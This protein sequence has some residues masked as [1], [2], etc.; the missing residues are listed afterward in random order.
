MKILTRGH[1]VR[2]LREALSRRR[3]VKLA[4][5]IGSIAERGLSYHD[6]DVAVLLDCN[7][8][9]KLR[10]LGEVHGDICKALSIGDDRLDLIP[11]DEVGW[12]LKYR[13]AKGIKLVD[14]DG[15]GV[16]L[17]EELNAV[18]PEL[19]LILDINLREWARMD[20]PRSIDWVMVKERMD[21]AH[22]SIEALNEIL[23]K[24][25]G[26]VLSS[27]IHRLAFERL[28]H[29]IVESILDVARHIVSVK[30]WGPAETYR[31]YV[32]ILHKQGVIPLEL[33]EELYKFI[34]WRNILVR[35]V[36]VDHSKLYEDSKK[37]AS[38]VR[39]F[40]RQVIRLRD[41]CGG[42]P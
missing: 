20:D 38:I 2:K 26:E 40:E 9:E 34:A 25:L 33:A 10:L 22:K 1:V 28:V 6:V 12:H 7:P 19:R 4:Y 41:R 14:R 42:R 29:T 15:A 37:L 3:E 21:Y 5:L 32:E 24:P 18:Y 36:E 16:K 23:A 27:T 17:I 39:E 30:G 11:I 31:D 35:Y 8:N 13:I